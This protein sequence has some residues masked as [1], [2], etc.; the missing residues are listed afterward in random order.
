MNML[1]AALA[2][3]QRLNWP[4]FPVHGI[5]EGKCACGKPGC[6]RPGKHPIGRLVPHG[7]KDAS[8]DPEVITRWWRDSPT[9][10]IGIV[11]GAE[12]GIVV[13]DVDTIK[14]GDESLFD[15]ERDHGKLPETV[16]AITG[17][18]GFHYLFQ[19]PGAGVK[20]KNSVDNLGVG[21]DVRGDGGYIVV[22]PSLHIS[23]RR[24]EWESSCRPLEADIAPLP[25][26]LFEKIKAA[27]PAKPKG[28][29]DS[30]IQL[31]P[32]M[33]ARIRAALMYVRS[34]DRDQWVE[35]G[36]SLHSTGAGQQAYGLWCEWAQQSDKFDAVDSARVWRS[37]T[38]DKTGKPDGIITLK[39]LFTRAM[40]SGWLPPSG[41]DG[42]PPQ[43]DESLSPESCGIDPDQD[44]KAGLICKINRKTGEVSYPCRAHNLISIIDHDAAWIGRLEF[45]EFRQQITDRGAEFTD[46]HEIELKAWFEQ[47]WIEGEVKTSVVREAVCAVANRHPVHP[48]RDKLAALAWDGVE[49]LPTFFTDFCGTPF[50]PYSEAV[51]RALFVSAVARIFKP[52]CKV[53]TM[54][55][56]EGSQGIGKSRLIQVL[57]GANW[58]CDITEA[59]GNL[60][61]Y[62]NLRGKWVGEFSELGSLGKADQNR[63]KQALSGTHDTYRASYGRNSRTYPRQFIFTGSTNKK[64]YLQDETGARRYLPVECAEIDIEAVTPLVSQLW[65]EAVCRH[66][67]GEKWWD[68]PDAADEQDQRYQ[69]DS[70]ED[71][72][73]AYLDKR[74]GDG[75][76]P[77]TRE[78]RVTVS[79]VLE[80]GLFLKI[81]KHGKS[82]QTRVGAIMARLKWRLKRETTGTVRKKYY[83]PPVKTTTCHT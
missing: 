37:F 21:L 49:R 43:A 26:W 24:Y 27:K 75:S 50:T 38:A 59:P 53:D 52:G 12:S 58:H 44:W 70:W 62:Q 41:N 10:N 83:V 65:A 40:E 4:V 33:V 15:L 22:S 77:F 18:G 48:V 30:D 74:I 35:V 32:L 81:E 78:I 23:G 42:I 29:A 66:Q 67:A 9:A 16:M 63:V 34:E 3:A 2:Y 55:V 6:D 13:L 25:G 20:V 5:V 19:H 72:V 56:L 11:T 73:S 71:Y 79:D 36:M 17:S 8:T 45:D 31:S 82:E 68:I 1:P 80:F 7:L 61:F 60:D 54:V 76:D 51:G 28:V 39:R 64:E 14:A 69:A 47:H 57:F 46:A